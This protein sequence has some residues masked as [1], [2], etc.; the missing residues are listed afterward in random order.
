MKNENKPHFKPG[1]V[2]YTKGYARKLF[3][4]KLINLIIL[5]IGLSIVSFTLYAYLNQPV[6]TESGY[7]TAEIIL[8][9]TPEIGDEIIVVQDENYNM[10]T[11]LKRVLVP[12]E[13]YKAEIIAGPY[14]EIKETKGRQ[15]VVF[16]E[17]TISVNLEN[18]DNLDDLYLDKEFIVREIVDNGETS[19][20]K[21]DTLVN[22]N[23][24]L[25]LIEK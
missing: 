11:P 19:G 21:K 18:L 13:I 1:A 7:V 3:F 15:T 10:F 6:K 8:Q 24:I 16:A 9:G 4:S 20:E 5:L 14:G 22:L 17:Q 12:Q 23:E 25:G 2:K